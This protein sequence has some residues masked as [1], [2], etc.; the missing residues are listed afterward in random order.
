MIATITTVGELA[1][2][3]T[4]SPEIPAALKPF[5]LSALNRV[6]L[7]LG[8]G[9]PDVSLEG[10]AIL[11][12]LEQ[13]SPAMAGMLP[14]SLANV[15]SRLRRALRYAMPHLAPARSQVRLEGEW[16][17]L[18]DRLPKVE[19]WRTSRLMRH[20]Q[21]MGWRP[22]AIGEEQIEQFAAHLEHAAMV[23]EAQQM[24]R[25]ARSAWNR[26]VATIPGWPG[27]QLAPPRLKRPPY[28]LR[29]HEL[30]A[31]LREEMA[32]YLQR[33][34]H[35]DPFLAA[36]GKALA[37]RTVRQYRLLVVTFASALAATGTPLAELTSLASLVRPDRVERVFR[38][39]YARAG[40]RV[41]EHIHQLAHR[42]CRIGADLDLP[43]REREGLEA[44]RAAVKREFPYRPGLTAK[45]RRLLEQVDE[46]GFVDRL[47]ALPRRL[48]EAAKVAGH[49]R[50]TAAKA[51]DA[52][53]A[54]L[55]LTCSM[56]VGNLVD[57]RLGETIRKFGEGRTARW[58]IEIPGEKVKNGQP[59]RFI[60]LPE[61]VRL[62]EW[63]LAECHGYW[64]GPAS[65]WLF[66][67]RGGGHVATQYLSYSLA[68]RARRHVGVAI[69][70]HQFR[71]LAAE[72]YLREDPTGLGVVSEHLGHRR[73]DTAKRF[74]AREQTRIAT[75]R[76][77]QVLIG[78]RAGA[79]L[80]AARVRRKT[81]RDREGAR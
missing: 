31:P 32:V 51:R 5:L 67:D 53:A 42:V 22:E 70:A 58:V 64:C 4:A 47:L 46:P 2:F 11:R 37:P 28:W 3:I 49:A 41:T 7:L 73:L 65:P 23:E 15:R 66:P 36:H 44:L 79:A 80:Q 21:T 68:G 25:V 54:E 38:F 56:R 45:N 1:A 48:A 27:R 12:R 10:G 29:E 59:L 35:P 74:Y 40:Q 19:R 50:S 24:A 43:D 39:L 6:R 81:G 69:T 52:V 33:L 20:C 13:L 76:Y 62:L 9:Q 78:K 60:L 17:A 30:P 16:L 75:E 72:I 71:H 14:Q 61:L 77:H 57:L 34:A 55:L 26:A 18:S 8:Q 63:Y